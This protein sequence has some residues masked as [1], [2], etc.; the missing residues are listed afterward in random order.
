M[1]KS[2]YILAVMFI[3]ATVMMSCSSQKC[4]AY[5]QNETQQEEVRS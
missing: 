5:G 2:Y 4:P 3:A 1:K